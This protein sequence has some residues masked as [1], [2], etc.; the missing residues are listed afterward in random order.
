M[1]SEVVEGQAV[2]VEVDLVKAVAAE[3][4]LVK[5]VAAE[6]KADS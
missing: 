5:A 6:V 3:M 2:A 1:D 4:D